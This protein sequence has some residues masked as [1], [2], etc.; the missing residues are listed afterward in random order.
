[1]TNVLKDVL[2]H[3]TEQTLQ[4][5]KGKMMVFAT[6]RMVRPV[7]TLEDDK[8]IKDKA[9]EAQDVLVRML[10]QEE[11]LSGVHA[12]MDEETRE[13]VNEEFAQCNYSNRL[14]EIVRLSLPDS[15]NWRNML[16]QV[17]VGGTVEALIPDKPVDA[18]D[19]KKWYVVLSS[20]EDDKP[21]QTVETMV[22]CVHDVCM[23]I[24]ATSR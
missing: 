14:D 5:N 7:E 20:W 10:A 6:L 2:Q 18:A 3:F 22:A 12:M 13:W 11:Q 4:A 19:L 16:S 23:S 21:E 17:R 1:M 15:F 24:L 9:I 8:E